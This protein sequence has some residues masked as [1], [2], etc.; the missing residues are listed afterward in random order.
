MLSKINGK[1]EHNLHTMKIFSTLIV[2]VGRVE[3][4][5]SRQSVINGFD[6]IAYKLDRL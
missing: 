4:N 5:L 1:S 3:I 2:K 6:F